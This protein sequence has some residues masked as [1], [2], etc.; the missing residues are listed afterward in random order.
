M[1]KIEVKVEEH[2]KK[3]YTSPEEYAKDV[4]KRNKKIKTIN[5]KK[6]RERVKQYLEASVEDW[7][8]MYF[9]TPEKLLDETNYVKLISPLLP[10]GHSMKYADGVAIVVEAPPRI[11][12]L[13]Y[14]QKSVYF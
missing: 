14:M 12:F 6:K 7:E 11:G 9:T 3:R 4:E 10:E 13:P 5:N 8:K 1:N 2:T